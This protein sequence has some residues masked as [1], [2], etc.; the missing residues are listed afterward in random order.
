MAILH[1][2]LWLS[3]IPLRIYTYIYVYIHCI[4]FIQSFVDGL[5]GCFRVLA[6]V[7]NASMN[8]GVHVSFKISGFAFYGYIPRS[9][10]VGSYGYSIFSLLS[11]LH[12]VFHSGCTN[13]DSH[14]Q[15]TGAPFFPHSF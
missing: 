2:F 13:L 7:N 4:F 14:Q 1:S 10:I 12:A 5:L 8:I 11:N 6:I 9:V 3:S 15:C